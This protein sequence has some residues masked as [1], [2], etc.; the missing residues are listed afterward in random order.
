MQ[1]IGLYLHQTQKL[2]L[3]VCQHISTYVMGYSIRVLKNGFSLGEI[4]KGLT[5]LMS[6]ILMESSGQLQLETIFLPS[7]AKHFISLLRQIFL[8][9]FT[10][11]VLPHKTC[12]IFLYS[13]LSLSQSFI[14]YLLDIRAHV[15][16]P[17]L[18]S[19]LTPA[20]LCSTPGSS[21]HGILQTRILEW[22]A[23]PFSRRSS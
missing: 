14:T 22:T 3:I 15:C 18:H 10:Y 12:H 5:H 17:L 23:L 2:S 9:S 6:S 1:K 19:C 7:H 20:T 13:S 21:V 16:A 8:L 4:V 11:I